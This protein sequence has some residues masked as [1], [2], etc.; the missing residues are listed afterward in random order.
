MKAAVIQFRPRHGHPE[1]ARAQLAVLIEGALRQ[2]AAH[3]V[4]PEMAVSGYVWQSFEEVA[5]CLE[6]SRGPTFALV[7][8]LARR[9]GAWV[10]VGIAEWDPVT[11]CAYNSALVIGPDG[12]LQTCYRKVLLF[13]LDHRWARSGNR[14]ALIEAGEAVASVAICM[15]INDDR[16]RMHLLQHDVD[17]LWFPTNWVEEGLDVWEYWRRRL[18]PWQGCLLA[19]NTWGTERGVRFSGRSV[20]MA[21]SGQVLASAPSAGDAV[22]LAVLPPRPL[23]RPPG[24]L[25]GRML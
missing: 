17:L 1:E 18:H 16:V 2:G 6:E 20:I 25:P 4:C 13:V 5:P 9:Y 7:A 11:L 19:A 22:V 15:D 8:P 10:V 14:R 21:P 24:V 23:R 12:T 3:V